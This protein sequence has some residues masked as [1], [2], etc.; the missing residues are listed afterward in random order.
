LVPQENKKSVFEGMSKSLFSIILQPMY[1]ILEQI[2]IPAV[3]EV[4]VLAA[5]NRGAAGF[6][7]TGK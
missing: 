3:V 5:S 1:L 4:S 7:S 2:S 6:G